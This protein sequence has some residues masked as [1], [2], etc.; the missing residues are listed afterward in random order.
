MLCLEEIFQKCDYY[1][2]CAKNV[3]DSSWNRKH[4]SCPNKIAIKGANLAIL[5]TQAGPSRNTG[6]PLEAAM[7]CETW[8]K[9]Q[10]Q[11]QGENHKDGKDM[12]RPSYRNQLHQILLQVRKNYCQSLVVL[13][14]YKLREE[15]WV[16]WE[17]RL[18]VLT[19][20]ADSGEFSLLLC[21]FPSD[22]H[23]IV[24]SQ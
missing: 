10:I 16:R 9:C 13:K 8:E 1:H 24:Q 6:V 14:T 7:G 23:Q 5:C 20:H 21:T 11:V 2:Y 12:A 3:L 18:L 22:G 4:A 19:M 17:F 15:R